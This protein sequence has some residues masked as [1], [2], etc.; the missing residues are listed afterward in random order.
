MEPGPQNSLGHPSVFVITYF[1]TGFFALPM[2][3]T[4]FSLSGLTTWE[5]V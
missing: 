2:K 1:L 3:V 5:V 4:P